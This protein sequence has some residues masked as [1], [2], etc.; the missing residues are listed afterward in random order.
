MKKAVFSILV[1]PFFLVLF[2]GLVLA[3]DPVDSF[4]CGSKLVMVGE[5]KH[6]V[7]SKCGEPAQRENVA[8]STAVK[9]STKKSGKNSSKKAGGKGTTV[10]EHS[11][12]DEQWTYNLGPQ[13]FVYVLSFEGAAL[14]EIGRGGRGARQ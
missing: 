2:A 8:R 5:T 13:N 1:L 14:R 11:R 12:V 10:E 4:R 7:I 3:L 9:K 6:E